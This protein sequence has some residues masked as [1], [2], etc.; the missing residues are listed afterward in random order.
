MRLVAS[1]PISLGDSVSAVLPL[2]QAEAFRRLPARQAIRSASSCDPKTKN[3][4]QRGQTMLHQTDQPKP[5]HPRAQTH[6]PAP[7]KRT[8]YDEYGG[9]EYEALPVLYA[10]FVIT[11]CSTIIRGRVMCR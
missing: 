1:G 8:K 11:L 10:I 7:P 9:I 3:G 6:S 2:A 5:P 4:S